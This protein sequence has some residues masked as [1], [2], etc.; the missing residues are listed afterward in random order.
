[1]KTFFKW[2]GIILAGLVGLFLYFEFPDFRIFVTG[3]AGF[4]VVYKMLEELIEST[5]RRVVR[6]QIQSIRDEQ[7]GQR[8]DLRVIARKI[9]ELSEDRQGRY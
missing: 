6:E 5:V 3:A 1:M 7:N 9:S 8:N 4:A 2:V